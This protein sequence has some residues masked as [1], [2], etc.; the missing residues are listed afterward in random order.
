M[1]ADAVE[2]S[3]AA[4]RER[5]RVCDPYRLNGRVSE[6]IGLVVESRGPAARALIVSRLL[7]P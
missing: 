6:L 4:A 5:M 1:L 2:R 3:F 7:M